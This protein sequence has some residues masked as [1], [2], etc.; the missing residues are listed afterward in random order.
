MV[1]STVSFALSVI[2]SLCPEFGT[3]NRPCHRNTRW[4]H[5]SGWWERYERSPTAAEDSLNTTPDEAYGR[6]TDPQRFATLHTAAAGV[7]A[8][9]EVRFAVA[10]VRSIEQRTTPSAGDVDVIRI[11][12]NRADQA[13]LT[14]TLTDFPG[15]RIAAGAW[16]TASLPS[17]GCDGCDEDAASEVSKLMDHVDR[18]TSGQFSERITGSG[19]PRLEYS[20]E[21][22]GSKRS[23]SSSL[24][25]ADAE[26]MRADPIQPPT[27]GRWLPWSE[28]TR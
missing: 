4:T 24:T 16:Y 20:W 6:V 2:S 12:P 13:P 7:V 11:A 26:R 25:L 1:R 27:V 8:A 17:C 3:F 18:V 10:I 19:A 14:I 9:L 28:R 22:E 21:T 5:T 15:L 23:S